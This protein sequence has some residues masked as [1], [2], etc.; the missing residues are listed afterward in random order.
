MGPRSYMWFVAA[1]NVV[2][3]CMTVMVYKITCCC[4]LGRTKK[5]RTAQFWRTGA[6]GRGGG[7]H[8]FVS[9]HKVTVGVVRS[10]PI[11]KQLIYLNKELVALNAMCWPRVSLLWMFIQIHPSYWLC[12]ARNVLNSTTVNSGSECHSGHR[13]MYAVR[14]GIVLV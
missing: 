3:R 12:G 9:S 8:V 5:R 1:K 11:L 4:P 14:R 13:C 7:E 6:G 10:G 2:M